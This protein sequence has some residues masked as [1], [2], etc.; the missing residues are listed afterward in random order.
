[1]RSRHGRDPARNRRPRHH[2]RR[3]STALRN[4]EHRGAVGSDAGTG[5]G[6]GILT[7]IPD[8]FLRAVVDFE[9]ARRRPLRRRHG[10][11]AHAT[12]TSARAVKAGIEALAADEQLTRA[13]LARRPDANPTNLGALARAA[14]PAFE[15]LFVCSRRALTRRAR[16]AGIE[17]ERQAFRC[18]SAPSASS[19]PTSRRSRAAR[20]STRAWSRRFSSSRSTPTCPT[21]ASSRSSLSCTRATRPTRSRRGRSPSRSA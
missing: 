13:R 6:A 15:Q 3:R 16:S 4:L 14:M 21:S 9:L 11:P 7:Q 12:P 10:L 17:L 2:R 8:A 18:A 19:M 5:D 1:M 20:S